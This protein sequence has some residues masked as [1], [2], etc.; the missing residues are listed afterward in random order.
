MMN[1]LIADIESDQHK[2]DLRCIVLSATEGAI[3]SA[4]HN[5]KEFA[6][7]SSERAA[8]ELIFQRASVLMQT[9]IDSPVPIIARIDGLAAAAGCQLVA[10]C[11][12]V[13]CSER[14]SFST[15]G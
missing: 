12:L 11:D 2:D 8:H 13:I 15:P 7:G 4:G 1:S 6:G 14:S 9:I 3:F 10:T 5:L